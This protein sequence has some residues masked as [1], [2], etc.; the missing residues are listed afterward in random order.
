SKML[1]THVS[2]Y[3]RAADKAPDENTKKL[4]L[5]K[6]IAADPDNSAYRFALATSEGFDPASAERMLI[7]LA[8][9]TGRGFARA[10]LIRASQIARKSI[11]SARDLRL[12]NHHATQALAG[13]IDNQSA[14]AEAHGLLGYALSNSNDNKN[15]LP[16]LQKAAE[17]LRQYCLPAAR[18]SVQLNQPQNAEKY[19]KM[20]LKNYT[21]LLEDDPKNTA[22]RLELAQAQ[23]FLGMYVAAY[24][25][26]GLIDIETLQPSASQLLIRIY[27]ALWDVTGGSEE[28]TLTR[29]RLLQ[30]A[31]AVDP[32]HAGVMQRLAKVVVEN[33][34]EAQVARRILQQQLVAGTVP[35]SVHVMLGF[36]ALRAGEG[37]SAKFHLE[38]AVRLEPNSE[39]IIAAL[40]LSHVETNA[41][42]PQQ[43]IK[44]LES[45]PLE[46]FDDPEIRGIRGR[47]L[48]A[49]G[50]FKSALTDLESSLVEL[51]QQIEIREAIATA[52]EKLGHNDV[53]GVHQAS[54]A[55]V[56]R[57]PSF[58]SLIS[59]PA[60]IEP[61]NS[62]NKGYIDPVEPQAS[63]PPSR[64]DDKLLPTISVVPHSRTFFGRKKI[65]RS[66]E[67]RA[68]IYSSSQAN[69]PLHLDRQSL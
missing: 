14:K 53:A 41:P 43:A 64:I 65:S 62:I 29:I 34:Q 28:A 68:Q 47:V 49:A 32:M 27:L 33:N 19:G 13:R 35:A 1:N 25:G 59:Q 55:N 10:H 37:D 51:P 42:Q 66:G 21:E 31:L 52:Y 63:V 17:V 22:F 57:R 24:D 44:L 3:A 46:A 15:A 61:S 69:T 39:K 18:L 23:L 50:Q 48:L 5:R 54:L 11:M 45:L 6:L 58:Q 4:Y 67:R 38:H 40:A 20:A 36:A 30:R 26:L 9:D 7:D 16:H 2:R 56:S 60:R 12:I 8:P